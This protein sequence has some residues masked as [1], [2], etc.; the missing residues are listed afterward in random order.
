VGNASGVSR[1]DRNR[2]ARLA[3]LRHGLLQ[4][5]PGSCSGLHTEQRDQ[6][7]LPRRST[8]TRAPTATPTP[9]KTGD[10]NHDGV[11]KCLTSRP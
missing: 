6:A 9:P 2:N 4:L 7:G 5:R 3:R 11:V 1:G 8:T 10:I